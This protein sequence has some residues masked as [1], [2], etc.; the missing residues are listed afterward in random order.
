MRT[1]LLRSISG[2]KR[3]IVFALVFLLAIIFV[4]PRQTQGLLE[5][6]GGPVADVVSFPLN[7]LAALSGGLHEL[8]EGYL[9][10]RG[11]YADNQRLRR[12]IEYL[13]GQNNQLREA[14]AA[15]QR[16]AGLLDFKER[17]WP[18]TIAARVIGRDSTNWYRGLL[19][20]KGER[21]GIRPDMGVITPGGMVGRVVKATTVSSVVLLLTDPNTAVTGLIQR[22]RDEGMVTGT[23]RGRLRM[24][25]IPLL[26]AVREGDMVVTSGLVGQFPKGL[27]IGVVKRIEKTEEDLFQSAELFPAV[28][29]S[30]LEEVL[31]LTAPQTS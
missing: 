20:D 15:G 26:S 30:K 17:S 8:W 24:K 11:V 9:S 5:Y 19:L 4:L 16:L 27:L 29:F 14:A 22:T 6:V 7:G 21:D 28:D 2:P 31:V 18:Q 10:L 3:A 25:Y 23:P 12:E 13:R 1:G